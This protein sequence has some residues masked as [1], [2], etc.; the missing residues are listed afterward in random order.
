ME[1]AHAKNKAE[2]LAQIERVRE[3]TERARQREA[4]LQAQV[5]LVYFSSFFFYLLCST[6]AWKE[7]CARQG[8][9]HLFSSLSTSFISYASLLFFPSS[10]KIELGRKEAESL[11]EDPLVFFSPYIIW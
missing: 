10:G 8:Q 2:I 5:P 7:E 1:E 11:Q 9:V 3:E 6:H 4:E